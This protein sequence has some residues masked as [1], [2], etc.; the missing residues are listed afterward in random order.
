[1]IFS[2][3]MNSRKYL[4]LSAVAI[5]IAIGTFIFN[6]RG[7][8]GDVH[9]T[10]AKC[11]D[12]QTFIMQDDWMTGV[13]D[14]EREY[15]AIMDWQRCGNP[16]K[17]DLVMYRVSHSHDPVV[18][19]VVAG[20]GDT[21]KLVKAKNKNSWN[22]EINGE[23]L[24]AGENPYHFGSKYPPALKLYQDARKGVLDQSS[25]LLF[26]MVPPGDQDSGSLGV[27]SLKDILGVVRRP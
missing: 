9:T 15:T 17:G 10:E 21:F 18:K 25:V 11:I 14:K 16:G 27:L 22:I 26:S 24:M 8:V 1:M 3:M 19:R 20:P 23:L 2:S 7:Q 4:I 12:E 5:V 6:R 13:L